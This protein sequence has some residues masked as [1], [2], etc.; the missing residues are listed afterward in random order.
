MIFIEKSKDVNECL[1]EGNGNTC[2][3]FANCENTIGSYT[4]SCKPGFNGTGD[5]CSGFFFLFFSSFNYKYKF[6]TN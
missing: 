5:S 3:E 1:G 6:D 4:C 2:S